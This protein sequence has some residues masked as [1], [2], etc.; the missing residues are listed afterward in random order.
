MDGLGCEIPVTDGGRGISA[1]NSVPRRCSR[2]KVHTTHIRKNGAD[3]FAL[4]V[5]RGPLLRV[6][7]AAGPLN[8]GV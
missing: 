3:R 2:S 6:E 7:T 1:K 8:V 4:H 5:L